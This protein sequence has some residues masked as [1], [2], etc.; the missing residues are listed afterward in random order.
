MVVFGW[1]MGK[2]FLLNETMCL[3]AT[4]EKLGLK[5]G[6]IGGT[7]GAP[8]Y[9]PPC[10]IPRTEAMRPPHPCK[11]YTPA[12]PSAA[13]RLLLQRRR[14]LAAPRCRPPAPPAARLVRAAPRTHARPPRA[15]LW[16]AARLAGAPPAAAPEAALA[17]RH[18]DRR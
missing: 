14:P 6:A 10:G 2:I 8:C 9:A 15:G 17:T 4:V 18:S 16:L 3:V 12:P 7:H 5:D 11:P 1:V 13:A